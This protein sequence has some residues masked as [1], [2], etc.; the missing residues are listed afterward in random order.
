[1]EIKI[2]V[3]TPIGHAR[4]LEKKLRIFLLGRNKPKELYTNEIDN[5][6]IWVIEDNIRRCL[7][8]Q[9]N[10]AVYDT[11]MG[12]T[13]KKIGK[14]KYIKKRMLPEQKD[15]LEDMLLNHTKI[16]IIK[17]AEAEEMIDD[18]TFWE[19]LKNRFKK[20]TVV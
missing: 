6:V 9:K 19:R 20:E 17:R 4:R 7:K 16:E 13:L 5:E 14:S 10:I 8:I 12:G 18:E 3:R 11:L 15:E 1:M 2:R